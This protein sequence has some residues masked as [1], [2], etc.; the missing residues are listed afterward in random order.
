MPMKKQLLLLLLFIPLLYGCG[1]TPIKVTRYDPI[2]LSEY[3]T[4]F[5]QNGEKLVRYQDINYKVETALFEYNNIMLMP[6]EI[7]NNTKTIIMPDDY[8][9]SLYDGRD[10]MPIKMLTRQEIMKV[11]AQYESGKSGGSLQEQA[12]QGTLSLMMH[13]LQPSDRSL[14]MKGLD[15]AID[16]Y[17]EFRPI[18]PLETRKGILCFFVDFKL[19]YPLSLN[20]NIKDEDISIEFLPR[21]K[22]IEKQ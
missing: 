20:V 4:V 3:L 2:V 12:I 21:P 1:G 17:F 15:K 9:L 19:E 8:S 22:K 6:I 11:K 14:I 13:A 16:D 7:T 18:Y 10:F 5:T